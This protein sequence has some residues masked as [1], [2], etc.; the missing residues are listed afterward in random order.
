MIIS[1]VVTIVVIIAAIGSIPLLSD[2]QQKEATDFY[3]IP[4]ESYF[5]DY[6]IKNNKVIFSYSICFVNNSEEDVT[7]AVSANFKKNEI[8]DWIKYKNFFMGYDENG[9]MKSELIKSK[10]KENVIFFFEGEYISDKINTN[11]SFP[12]ELILTTY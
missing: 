4:E 5:V 9:I 3:W 11:L 2:T 8:K 7:V 10:E 6:K 1:V 12:N